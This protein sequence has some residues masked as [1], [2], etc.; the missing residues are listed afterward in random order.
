MR[1][2]LKF[3]VSLAFGIS[4][5]WSLTGAFIFLALVSVGGYSVHEAFVEVGTF[6]VIG[7]I[8]L[9]VNVTI[10][11]VIRVYNKLTRL[12]KAETETD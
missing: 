5:A 10:F 3:I 12:F 7:C 4:I 1:N 11:F 8:A 2:K 6:L 9:A